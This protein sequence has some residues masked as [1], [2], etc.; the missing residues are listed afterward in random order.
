MVLPWSSCLGYLCH[1]RAIPYAVVELLEDW[2][3]ADRFVSLLTVVSD[4]LTAPVS[5]MVQADTAM[6]APPLR[7]V[8]SCAS[9]SQFAR[10]NA[11]TQAQ[12]SHAF[13]HDSPCYLTLQE[14]DEEEEED[15][16][17]KLKVGGI[18]DREAK[19]N[20][21]A[22]LSDDMLLDASSRGGGVAGRPG[23][24]VREGQGSRATRANMEAA[25]SITQQ[26][27]IWPCSC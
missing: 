19:S 18:D 26:Q 9:N 17:H 27:V 7:L 25:T 22:H 4:S 13:A 21:P 23:G 10:H 3:V 12:Q 14:E 24:V 11:C 16:L 2:V 1:A 6:P 15:N 20:N 5:V 8:E